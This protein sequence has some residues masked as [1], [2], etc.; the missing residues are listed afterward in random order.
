MRLAKCSAPNHAHPSEAASFLK[1]VTGGVCRQR[2][3]FL[4]ATR[5]R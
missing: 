5:P 2:S 3:S 1:G 4:R